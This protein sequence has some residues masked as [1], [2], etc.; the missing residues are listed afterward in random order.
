MIQVSDLAL[1]GVFHCPNFIYCLQNIYALDIRIKND[2][3]IQCVASR[4]IFKISAVIAFYLNKFC[5]TYILKS[6]SVKKW[7]YFLPTVK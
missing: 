1:Q 5:S 3:Y 7:E 4:G 2:P 6:Y